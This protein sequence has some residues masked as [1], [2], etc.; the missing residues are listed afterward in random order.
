MQGAWRI[1]EGTLHLVE[2]LGGWPGA[3]LAQQTMRHKTVKL[4]LS[5]RLLVDR[6]GPRRV[7]VPVVPWAEAVTAILAGAAACAASLIGSPVTVAGFS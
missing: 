5:G 6:G 3:F 4:S 7:L 2:A 1:R